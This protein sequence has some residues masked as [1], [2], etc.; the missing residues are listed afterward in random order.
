MNKETSSI[1]NKLLCVCI[2]ILKQWQVIVCTILI[3]GI[4]LDIFQTLTYKPQYTASA[5]VVIESG[6][7]TYSDTKTADTYVKTLDYIFD[8]QVV[9]DYVKTQLKD[10]YHPYACTITSNE[11]PN[12]ITIHVVSDTKQSSFYSLKYILDWYQKNHK[13]YQLNDQLN[14]LED[15]SFSDMPIQINSHKR[16]LIKGSIIGAVLSFVILFFFHFIRSTVTS[17]KEIESNIDSRLFTKIPRERKPRNKKFWKKNRKAIL[18]DSVKTSFFYKEALKKLRHRLEESA[19][20]HHYQSVLITSTSENEGKS[21][22]CANIAIGLGMKDRKVLVIDADYRK[23]SLHK[24]FEISDSHARY[25]NDYFNGKANW[26]D[27]VYHDVKNHVDVLLADKDLPHAEEYCD[28]ERM[29]TLLNEAKKEYDYVLID[30]SPAGYLNDAIKLNRYCDCS[31]LIVKQNVATYNQI[32]NTI[33]RLSTI[34]SN[35]LGVV[36]NASI[37]QFKNRSVM[38]NHRNGYDRYYDRNRRG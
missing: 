14:V 31:L 20:K 36:Y 16:N 10:A 24:I 28:H 23:P 6:K 7:P 34:K 15:V 26:K 17:S 27:L 1:S 21:S 33:S 4:G 35:L 12:I 11:N 37:Y 8:T 32:N 22:I 3:F 38:S 13:T 18:I 5:T 9:N 2:N 25:G 29:E 19:I 30:S